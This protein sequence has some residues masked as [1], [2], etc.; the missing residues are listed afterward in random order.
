M[1]QPIDDIDFFN[2]IPYEDLWI[3]DKL[4]LSKYLG[5]KCGPAGSLPENPCNVIVKPCVNFRGMSVG[6]QILYL[7]A[8]EKVPHGFFWCEIFEGRHL[9]FDYNH[10][11]QVLAVEGFKDES[12]RLDRFSLWKKVSDT[13]VLPN[14]IKNIADKYEWLNI[15]V[16]G[17]CVIDVHL[18]RNSNFMNHNGNEIIPIWKENFYESKNQDRIGFIVKNT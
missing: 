1:N 12:K 18:R 13:F 10:G 7:D 2:N 4:I 5:Y 14:K 15:E 11:R 8:E 6:A 9:S 3:Y 17:N 16:I